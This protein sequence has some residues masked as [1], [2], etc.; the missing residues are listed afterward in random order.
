MVMVESVIRNTAHSG[1]E[2][3]GGPAGAAGG[4]EE[5]GDDGDG[6]GGDGGGDIIGMVKAL[7]Q[8]GCG[9]RCCMV[10]EMQKFDLL[11]SIA[12]CMCLDG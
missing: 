11:S 6:G 10:S 1:K 9:L 4:V 12:A 2:G 7:W 3:A 5:E 8:W